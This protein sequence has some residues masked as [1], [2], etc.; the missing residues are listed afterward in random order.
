M[1]KVVLRRLNK[2]NFSGI[3]QRVKDQ[4]LIVD[5]LQRSLLTSPDSATA[6]E[7]HTQR[8]KLNVLLTA[9]EKYYRQRSRVR[10]ADVRDRNTVFYHRTVTQHVTRNHIHF[11]KDENDRVIS[12]TNELKTHSAQ[13]FQSILGVT[14]LPNSLAPMDELH[15]LLPFR[16]SE[17]QQA[18]LARTVLE[19]EIK[20][21][22]FSM[23]INESPGPDGYSI[24]FIRASWDTVG[25]DII[26]A[27]SEFFRNGRL[28]KDLNTKAIAL[29][30]KKSE[31]CSLGD[32]RPISCCNII[33]KVIS[34]IIANR[35][36][37]ILRE[38]V[39]PNQAAFLKGR[40]LGENVLLASELIQDYNKASCLRSTMLKVNIHKALIRC[41]GI[42]LLKS[43]KLKDSQPYLFLGFTNAL[44]LLDS[45]WL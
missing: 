36:K 44:L 4:K 33:Y 1:L 13:Y 28:L 34:K 43:S 15:D 30:P 16:C 9:E 45:R 17:I 38:C 12:T 20:G 35:L 6:R 40:S 24:E 5:G 22:I 8:G 23:P 42:L 32:Y 7:E 14:D 19:P 31:A 18:Y 29:I 3:S 41:A 39:S 26:N 11:L 2:Q 21:T 27:V 10:W 37:P 25:P